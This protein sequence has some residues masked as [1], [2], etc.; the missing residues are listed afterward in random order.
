MSSW[1]AC[2]IWLLHMMMM[3]QA[4]SRPLLEYFGS[5]LHTYVYTYMLARV[6]IED[7]IY[8]S[9]ML[10]NGCLY[11]SIGIDISPL[12][13]SPVVLLYVGEVQTWRPTEAPCGDKSVGVQVE[14]IRWSHLPVQ[15]DHVPHLP[16]LP[17]K[18]RPP[19]TSSWSQILWVASP[20]VTII[21]CV[22]FYIRMSWVFMS[23]R[24]VQQYW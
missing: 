5:K 11:H 7:E 15:P 14:D 13:F 20:M 3:L 19:P 17:D 24:Y 10:W 18:L 4:W 12:L 22:F 1:C 21:H 9:A 6:Q 23:L 2:V 8:K 16:P